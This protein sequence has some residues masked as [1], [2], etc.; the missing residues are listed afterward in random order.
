[1]RRAYCT[2]VNDVQGAHGRPS[3]DANVGTRCDT[4][5]RH[6][7]GQHAGCACCVCGAVLHSRTG[8]PVHGAYAEAH[9]YTVSMD[10]ARA[11][12]IAPGAR[13]NRLVQRVLGIGL[14][15]SEDGTCPAAV[16]KRGAVVYFT[17]GSRVL[18]VSMGI[19]GCAPAPLEP[20]AVQLRLLAEVVRSVS[21]R[22]LALVAGDG[23]LTVFT[24]DACFNIRTSAPDAGAILAPCLRCAH[25]ASMAELELRVLLKATCPSAAG[26][27]GGSEQACVH[28]AVGRGIAICASIEGS[29]VSCAAAPCRDGG[30]LCCSAALPMDSAREV[31]RLLG[32]SG[33]VRIYRHGGVLGVAFGKT[34]VACRL[35]HADI[36]DAGFVLARRYE[37][38]LSLGCR[39]LDSV[40]R[41]AC[42]L[43]EDR[44]RDL[45]ILVTPGHLMVSASN[46]VR[47]KMEEVVVPTG[48]NRCM[49][50]VELMVNA[51]KV[52]DVLSDASPRLVS[53]HVDAARR[54]V[55]LAGHSGPV[56]HRH[57]LPLV[58]TGFED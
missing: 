21:T 30:A 31:A 3:Y 33:T 56:A 11:F 20:A 36:T 52:R 28:L 29:R 24:G 1:M 5:R 41:R 42:V 46:T 51:D 55:M 38:V 23:Y 18:Q 43:M 27:E 8:R 50:G 49:L 40:L 57:I 15:G 22:T 4:M 9:Q 32:S 54:S 19:E 47:E 7:Q 35:A 17:A 16:D 34:E 37:Y 6:L 12:L 13:L 48:L 25:V 53:F 45:S 44:I 2:P 14:R 10:S 58:R 26:G 39:E